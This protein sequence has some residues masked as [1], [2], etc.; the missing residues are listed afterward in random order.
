MKIVLLEEKSVSLGDVSLEAFGKLGNVTSYPSTPNGKIIEYI[1]DAEAVIL[2]KYVM[3]EE[4]MKS[5]PN[6]KYIGLCATGYNNVDTE[7]ARRLGITV[8]NVP[9]YSTDA[10]AQQVF[11]YVLY[12]SNRV[13]DYSEDVHKGGWV[14][15]EMFCYFDIPMF[16]LR[17]LTMGIIGM[18]SIGRRV[19]ELAKAFGMKVIASTR[20]PKDIPDVEFMPVD[21]IFA[22]A[23]IISLHCP[24]T[25]K[26]NGLVNLDRLKLCKPSAVLINTSRGPVVNEDDLAYALNNNIIAAAAVDVVR[27]EPM[28]A[29]NTL[30]NAK[31]CII[32][33]H[34]SWAPRQ[35]RQRVVDMA[36]AN[37]EAFIKGEPIN[38]VM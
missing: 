10:V 32:T 8:C 14:R 18:G 27:V 31:N 38:T 7:A 9:D 12:F 3:T 35:T 1:D 37:L 17:G 2:N 30:L 19:S 34:T 20:T 21:E 22:K 25:D 24:L 23:D 26:T 13:S 33:P 5:C 4:I 36:A 15:S 6:L 11:S 29:D 28:A 16:E